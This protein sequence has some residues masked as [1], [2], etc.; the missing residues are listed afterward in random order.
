M[1]PTFRTL[2]WP[3]AI[4]GTEVMLWEQRDRMPNGQTGA[5]PWEFGIDM[6]KVLL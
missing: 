2:A 1:F 4:L 6:H 3:T 5:L